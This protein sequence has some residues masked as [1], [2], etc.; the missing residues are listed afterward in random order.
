[1]IDKTSMDNHFV[2]AGDSESVDELLRRSQEQ[3]LVIFK[4]SLTCS[5]SADAYEEMTRFQGRVVLV[6]VQRARNLSREIENKTGIGHQSPQVI[7]LFRGQV[8]WNASHWEVRADTVVEA[9][10]SLGCT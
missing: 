1:M 7:V 5:L 2:E 8:V 10:R 3:P 6:P 9:L 4:H